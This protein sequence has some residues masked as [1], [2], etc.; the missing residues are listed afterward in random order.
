MNQIH[1]RD[2]ALATLH[3][4]DKKLA[5][6]FNISDNQPISQLNC[7]KGLADYFDKPLPVTGEKNTSRKRAWTHKRVL[8]RKIRETGW[9]PSF[10]Q[11]FDALD[12]LTSNS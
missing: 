5:G 7:Y 10:P 9:E 3:L 8:N 2:A 12:S 11:Y 6:I 1:V 4:A